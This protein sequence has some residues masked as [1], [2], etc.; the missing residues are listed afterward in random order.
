MKTIIKKS[1]LLAVGIITLSLA[2]C[3]N[4]DDQ[5]NYNVGTV[6]SL[7]T[8]SDKKAVILKSES[9]ATL[10]FEW[11]PTKAEDNGIVLYDVIFDKVGG[12]FS[13]PCYVIPSDGNGYLPTATITHKTLNK[14]AAAAGFGVGETGSV[15]WTV[16]SSKGLK[17]NISSQSYTL[18][19]TRLNGLDELPAAVYIQGTATEKGSTAQKLCTAR[20]INTDATEGGIFEIYT[21]LK[22]GQYTI[23]DDLNRTF[24]LSSTATIIESSTPI[25]VK[26]DEAGIYRIKLDFTTMGATLTKIAKMQFHSANW[27]LDISHIYVDMVYAGSGIWKL[28]N[29]LFDHSLNTS[30]TAGDSRHRFILTTSDDNVEY[31]GYRNSDSADGPSYTSDYMGVYLFD[32]NGIGETDWGHC[33]KLNNDDCGKTMDITLYMNENNDAGR[34]FHTLTNI[35]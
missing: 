15:I 3:N 21:E 8:P 9:S 32:D 10:S 22:A 24:T 4:N 17:G 26:S 6:S 13:K 29:Y 31:L 16:R 20:A 14:V 28:S 1:I 11:E 35:H 5:I 27:Q 18:T 19:I 30:G 34:Y 2:G 7:Y 33:W 23:T 12:D 25:T